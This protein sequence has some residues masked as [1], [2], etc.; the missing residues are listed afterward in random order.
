M[1]LTPAILLALATLNVT[2]ARDASPL[3][4]AWALA[5]HLGPHGSHPVTRDSVE[6]TAA[7]GLCL[8]LARGAMERA[9]SA[10]E[11]VLDPDA[12]FERTL[13]RLGTNRVLVTA[14]VRA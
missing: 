11:T 3:L 2:V 5:L 7:R 10:A 9:E 1:S 12:A 4:A 6:E 14:G 13:A 8:A